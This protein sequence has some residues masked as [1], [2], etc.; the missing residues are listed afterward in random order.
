MHQM[1]VSLKTNGQSI[2]HRRAR[3][4]RAHRERDRGSPITK[5]QQ[6]DVLGGLDAILLQVF[7][8]LLAACKSSAL[9]GRR[10]ASHGDGA[11]GLARYARQRRAPRMLAVRRRVGG[12]AHAFTRARVRLLRRCRAR[13]PRHE[14]R[15]RNAVASSP[16]IGLGSTGWHR[17][18]GPMTNA[19]SRTPVTPDSLRRLDLPRPGAP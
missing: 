16:E 17:G 11:H 18:V 13:A 5:E 8:D 15:Y 6:L 12:A 14:L 10:G 3:N 2:E 7:L 9:L 19:G 1:P 4:L